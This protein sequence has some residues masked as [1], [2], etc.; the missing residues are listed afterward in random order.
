MSEIARLLEEQNRA[1]LDFKTKNQN[2]HEA[3]DARLKALESKGSVDP[4]TEER[5]SKLGDDLKDLSKSF[6]EVEKKA[7]RPGG[8]GAYMNNRNSE[9][10]KSFEKFLH[11][12]VKDEDYTQKSFSIINGS[13]GGYAVPEELDSNLQKYLFDASTMRQVSSVVQSYSADYKVAI[14]TGGLAAGWVG[15]TNERPETGTPSIALTSAPAGELYCNPAATQWM[16]DDAGFDLTSWL[17]G[18]ING[19]FSAMEGDAFISGDGMN[20]PKGFLSYPSATTDDSTRAFGTLKHVVAAAADSITMDELIDFSMDLRGVYR[21]NAVWLMNSATA[22]MLRKLKTSTGGD[23]LW[24]PSLQVG[25]PAMLLGFP[26]YLDES[27]P[28]IAAD[29]VPVALGDFKQ[30]YRIIDRTPLQVLRD[31]LTNKPYVHF[32]STKRVSGMLIDSNAI[33]LFKMAAA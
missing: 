31:S 18:E 32:Y 15:E 16:I 9:Q 20:K 25:Q 8:L 27:M 24:Q 3:V 7:N 26:V 21:R 1:F 28:S 19:K 11:T 10:R 6:Y 4:L 23:Y 22:A 30:G 14:N 2:R 12:G 5:I 13:D 29:T 33:R 17:T